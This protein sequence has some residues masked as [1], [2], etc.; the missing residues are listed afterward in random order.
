MRYML[1]LRAHVYWQR[2]RQAVSRHYSIVQAAVCRA[3]LEEAKHMSDT[4]DQTTASSTK[5]VA[6]A[7]D[8]AVGE[9][10]AAAPWDAR[11]WAISCVLASLGALLFGLS[12]WV[13]WVTATGYASISIVNGRQQFYRFLLDPA[14]ID[15]S[16]G[17]F[18]GSLLSIAGVL[19]LPFL[20]QHRSRLAN[21][22]AL[23]GYWAWGILLSVFVTANSR[24]FHKGST[25]RLVPDLRL[26]SLM[27]TSMP[28]LDFGYWLHFAA[29]GIVTLAAVMLPVTLLPGAAWARLY[30]GQTSRRMGPLARVPGMGTLTLGLIIWALGIFLFPWATVNCNA[31]PLLVGTCRGVPFASVLQLGL[32][33]HAEVIDPLVALYAVGLLL[34]GS[35]VLIFLASWSSRITRSFYIWVALWLLV[36]GLAAVLGSS[37]VG[38]LVAN[39]VAAGLEPGKWSGDNGLAATFLGLLIGLGALLYLVINQVRPA[40][41]SQATDQNSG[42]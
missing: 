12:T 40:P 31:N 7:P 6:E 16:F 33:S 30:A 21:L 29:L 10:I 9:E 20:W 28:V 42:R 13:P 15:G 17:L 35:A 32:R 3:Q 27:F 25:V 19:L 23:A 34:G 22:L 4:S 1:D 2:Q 39:P 8:P 5:A 18:G 36:A 37:G 14:D 24:Y 41:S 11:L 38:V 26:N